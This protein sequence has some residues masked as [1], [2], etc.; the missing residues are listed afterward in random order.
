MLGLMDLTGI[1]L[2]TE[3]MAC[4]ATHKEL[5]VLNE[6]MFIVMELLFPQDFF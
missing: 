6:Y 3:E 4:V 1:P 2:L 5:D